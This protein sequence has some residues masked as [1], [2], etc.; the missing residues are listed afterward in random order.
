MAKLVLIPTPIG[1]LQD[2]TLRAIETLKNCEV[3]LA[4]DTRVSGKLLKHLQIQKPIKSYHNANEHK[5]LQNT[6][7]LILNHQLVGLLTDAGTPAISDPGYLLV[8]A[9]IENNIEVE[10]LP[11]ATAFVPAL[12][13]SG[14][15]NETFVFEGFLPHKK[16]RQKKLETLKS[17]GK[18]AVLYESPYRLVKL[19]KEISLIFGHDHQ[20][21]TAREISKI[22]ETYNRGSAN[23]LITFFE[24]N[25]PK[26]EFV[27]LIAPFTA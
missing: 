22:Y 2:I 3:L 16:G 14:L 9:C 17:I 7:E 13:A 23:E 19:L 10:C 11:G 15:P 25:T 20:V 8:K 27:V 21:V 24:A 5:I 26:G 18:T 1:N 6:V 12:A 4:E